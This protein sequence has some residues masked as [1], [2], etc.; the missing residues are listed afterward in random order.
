MLST[1]VPKFLMIV[2]QDKDRDVVIE[3]LEELKNMVEKIGA[4]VLQGENMLDN[5]MNIVREVIHRKVS[6]FRIKS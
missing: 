1:T 6:E 2:K 5:W 4:P 3:T